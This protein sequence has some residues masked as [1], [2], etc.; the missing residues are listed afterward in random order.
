[1]PCGRPCVRY[2]SQDQ[3]K[4][5]KPLS[6]L[7]PSFKGRKVLINN[8]TK[9]ADISLILASPLYP[10]L[11]Q[12]RRAMSTSCT[13]GITRYRRGQA[14]ILGLALLALHFSRGAQPAPIVRPISFDQTVRGTLTSTDPVLID[15][16]RFDAYTFTVPATR[17]FFIAGRSPDIPLYSAVHRALP[18]GALIDPAGRLASG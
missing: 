4:L 16:T 14:I 11:T 15:Q 3:L 1:M 13:T 7:R 6:G 9:S 10:T 12:R 5:S 2:R 18:G 17:P 8:L